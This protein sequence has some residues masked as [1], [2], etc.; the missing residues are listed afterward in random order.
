MTN[1]PVGLRGV[2]SDEPIFGAVTLTGADSAAPAAP[3]PSL[4]GIMAAG[5]HEIGIAF[6]PT[7]APVAG[8]VAPA[9]STAAR[10]SAA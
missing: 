9:L 3:P 6:A 8:W 4:V 5:E 10:L 2:M 7:E 1:V